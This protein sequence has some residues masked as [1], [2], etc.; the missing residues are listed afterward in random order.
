MQDNVKTFSENTVLLAGLAFTSRTETVEDYLK[1]RVRSLTV[2]A[3][4][5]CFL[6][7]NLSSCRVYDT[8]KLVKEFK[9]PNFRIRDYKWYRQ[10]LVILVF[11]VNWLSVCYCL[12]KLKK[13]YDIYL[14][15]SHSF[16]LWGALLKKSGIAKKLIYYCI[17]Y[18]LPDKKFNFNSSFVR[19]LNRLDR[20]T[21]KVADY[22]WDL[23]PK[24][25]EYREKE[26]K[27][28]KDSYKSCIVP[29]GYSRH[30][31]KVKPFS[32]VRR[33]D[34]GFV[35]SISANQG[36]QL[37]VEAMPE[38]L[39]E[40]PQATATIIGQGPY[41]NDLKEMVV[42]K[43]LERHFNFLGFIKDENK[44]LDILSASAIGLALYTDSEG[45]VKCA[46]TGKPKLYALL[47]LPIITTRAYILNQEIIDN[48]SGM[49]VDYKKDAVIGAIFSLLKDDARLRELRDNSY[50]FGEQFISESIFDEAVSRMEFYK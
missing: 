38:V 39:K 45:N 30:L 23:S 20:F 25:P 26:G 42:K 1:S 41:L 5:S 16:G 22:I 19:F 15:I 48:R 47:G 49:V 2:I 29:L 32:E 36:L 18:Y 46:D 33:W 24:I 13:K 40:F 44:M 8:A 6:K 31:R 4:S 11:I 9:I 12:L 3:I 27:I 43:K 28:K 37:L 34:I 17:D 21:V 10:P 50:R 7:E 14:G 35:G